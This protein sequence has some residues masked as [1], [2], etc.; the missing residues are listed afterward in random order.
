MPD[1][2]H[3]PISLQPG[4]GARSAAA[5]ADSAP[6][7]GAAAPFAHSL[8]QL[9][10]R[11]P[12][13]LAGQN[14]AG[15]GGTDL[16]PRDQKL[17]PDGQTG[18]AVWWQPG[19][20]AAGEGEGEGAV[21]LPVAADMPVLPNRNRPEGAVL[22]NGGERQDRPLASQPVP[23]E[24]LRELNAYL[25]PEATMNRGPSQSDPV[26]PVRLQPGRQPEEGGQPGAAGDQAADGT[27]GRA[28]E[29]AEQALRPWQR[30]AGEPT[31][32][33]VGDSLRSD[34]GVERRSLAGAGE[35]GR[36]RLSDQPWPQPAAGRRQGV[37]SVPDDNLPPARSGEGRQAES[38]AQPVP[39]TSAQPV[40]VAANRSTDS[41]AQ[42]LSVAANAGMAK[43]LST[44]PSEPSE[45]SL[46][47]VE[48]SIGDTEPL[49]RQS[50]RGSEPLELA[51]SLAGDRLQR[52]AEQWTSQMNERGGQSGPQGNNA[53]VASAAP[54]QAAASVSM[55]GESGGSTNAPAAQGVSNSVPPAAPQSGAT[56]P[57]PPLTT[58]P[59]SSVEAAS[60]NA[61]NPD[62]ALAG[63]R[64]AF[65]SGS[66]GQSAAREQWGEALSQ[67]ISLMT[68]RNQSE[69]RVQLDPP[70]LGRLMIQI[71]VN[72]DQASV[73]FTSPHAMVREA[74]EA[75]VPRLQDMLSGQG[76][77]LLDVDIS[78]QSQQQADEQGEDE[79]ALLAGT[80]G[81][82][83]AVADEEASP[84]TGEAGL[85]LVDDYA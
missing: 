5:M 48:R 43:S 30:L 4:Q 33:T 42:S 7:Q 9:L 59:G 63:S 41:A 76:L 36:E 29:T 69:A 15:S 80:G 64:Q 82:E 32:R 85:S 71:Q 17:P 24:S 3:L 10:Q 79:R 81:D 50:S 40:A 44:E 26:Q 54:G 56:P 68:A 53:S 52:F 6:D 74:L 46:R 20:G 22:L 55:N 73:S 66:A 57:L 49:V 77:D 34:E 78:D 21:Q 39:A 25:N 2:V 37:E 84:L 8:S 13:D 38:A 58:V 18:A 35:G 45:P 60:R 31:G 61:V 14:A 19:S 28:P 11:A 12:G 65:G 23:R 47:P 51:S 1:P 67:R 70:E 16:P 62:A 72:S 27:R 75:S 83:E